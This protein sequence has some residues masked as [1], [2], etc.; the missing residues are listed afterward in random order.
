MAGRL[1]GWCVADRRR[2]PS[3]AGFQVDSVRMRDRSW[4][5]ARASGRRG[6]PCPYAGKIH[7]QDASLAWQVACLQAAAVRLCTQSAECETGPGDRFIGVILLQC[8]EEM[9]QL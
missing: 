7:H 8:A 2:I 5:P 6:N 4:L 3:S 9:L 1:L